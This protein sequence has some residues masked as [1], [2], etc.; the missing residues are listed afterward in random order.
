MCKVLGKTGFQSA[1]YGKRGHTQMKVIWQKS[2]K[3][4]P[5]QKCG[6]ALGKPRGECST[7]GCKCWGLTGWGEGA[8]IGSQRLEFPYRS[9][10]VGKESPT[11]VLRPHSLPSVPYPPE[12]LLAEARG[13]GAH[14][15][16]PHG[17]A[18]GGVEQNTG[19]WVAGESGRGRC[20]HQDRSPHCLTQSN[21]FLLHLFFESH[22][23]DIF[24]HT[25]TQKTAFSCN[26]K[27][28]FDKIREENH[29]IS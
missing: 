22:L 2:N 27:T 25:L 5:V 21:D 28:D 20:R 24:V 19:G 17:S 16:C 1:P 6:Q 11:L 14:W 23:W 10:A 26:W 13:K 3:R 29:T 12:L 15:G 8:V 7:R 4:D 18:S 9:H